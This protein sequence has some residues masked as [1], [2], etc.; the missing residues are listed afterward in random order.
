M[1]EIMSKRTIYTYTYLYQSAIFSFEDGLKKEQKN[2]DGSFYN[3]LNAIILSAFTIEAYLN[4][5]G[6]ELIEYWECIERVTTLDKLRIISESSGAY[7]DKSKRPY[8]TIKK[9]IKLRNLLA[10]AKTEM[11][12]GKIQYHNFNEVHRKTPKSEWEKNCNKTSVKRILDDTDDL[13][14]KIHLKVFNNEYPFLGMG[15][16]IYG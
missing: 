9:L 2:Q 3:F 1:K 7:F 4:H 5:C 10:H 16:E 11:L 12:E 14:K 6:E 13:I 8:Q 15:Y